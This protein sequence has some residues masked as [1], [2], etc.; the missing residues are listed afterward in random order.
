MIEEMTGR[1]LEAVD[2]ELPGFVEGLYLVGSA[3]LHAWQPGASDIDTVIL[4]SRPAGADERAALA[5]VHANLPSTPHLDGVYLDPLLLRTFPDARQVTPFVVDGE[6]RFDEPCGE[7]NPVLWLT[8]RRH[9]RR[10]RGPEVADLGIEV[11][12]DAVRRFN[13]DNLRSYWQ[14]LVADIPADL[15]DDQPI[16]ADPVV[17]TVLGPA[18]LHHT[19]AFGDVI[20]KAEAGAY[21]G[22][23]FPAY[24]EIAR[25]AI[26]HRAGEPQEFTLRD[27]RTAAASVH[28]V[29]DDAW[30]RFGS[31]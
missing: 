2:G 5:K 15:P 4:T 10:V 9:G 6:P 26:A 18:R 12:P 27:L 16:P 17:W 21:L 23:L 20:S 13:L 31:A 24:A 29:A 28:A 30:A 14:P 22:S 25:R 19:L 7:L 8:L 3:A 1:Y 11:R